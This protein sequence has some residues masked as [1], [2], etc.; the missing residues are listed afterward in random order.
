MRKGNA[1]RALGESK[2]TANHSCQLYHW[3]GHQHGQCNGILEQ[4]DQYALPDTK[5]SFNDMVVKACAM[6]LKKTPT[7]SIHRMV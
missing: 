6:A 5:V 7:R 2:F 3:H 1:K 4:R